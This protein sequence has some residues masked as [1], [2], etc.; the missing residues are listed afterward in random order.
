[1]GSLPSLLQLNFPW[2]QASWPAGPSE[3]MASLEQLLLRSQLTP[4]KPCPGPA[5]CFLSLMVKVVVALVGASD[6]SQQRPENRVTEGWGRRGLSFQPAEAAAFRPP[7][8]S[9]RDGD[10]GPD[11]SLGSQDFSHYQLPPT[12]CSALPLPTTPNSD[13]CSAGDIWKMAGW[14]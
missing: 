1:M 4:C 10:S 8:C 12:L 7:S 2:P 13:L 3:K 6:Q 5:C 14:G 9:C 11:H